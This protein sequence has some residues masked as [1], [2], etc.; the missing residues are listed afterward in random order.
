[1]KAI[2]ILIVAAMVF[3]GAYYFTWVLYLKPQREL[4]KEHL[5]PPPPPPLDPTIPE[6]ERCVELQQSAHLIQARS[7]FTDFLEHFP[8]STKAADVKSRLGT[9][10]AY[11]YLS[12]YPAPEKQTYIVK[13]GDLIQRVA[14]KLKTTPELIIRQNNMQ[15]FMLRYGQKL[16]AAPAQFSIAIDRRKRR[17]VLLNNSHFFK[18]Y[19]MAAAEPV[20]ATSGK[21]VARTPKPPK[22]TGKVTDEIAWSNGQRVTLFDKDKGEAYNDADHWILIAPSGHNLYTEHPPDS[23]DPPNKPPGGGYPLSRKDMQELASLLSKNSPVTIE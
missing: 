20:P 18:E 6:Y 11:I 3:G 15:G 1:M 19:Q 4:Q 17:V 14:S 8:E 16:L 7:A 22:V 10:N 21:K 2:A 9:I 5:E 23:K 12:T 13:K